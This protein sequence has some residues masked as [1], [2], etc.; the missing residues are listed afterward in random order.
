[1]KHI[2][3]CTF[4]GLFLIGSMCSNKY[5]KPNSSSK[6]QS[7]RAIQQAKPYL[8]YPGTCRQALEFYEECFD[9]EITMMQTFKE[10]SVDVPEELKQRIFNSEFRA[11]ELCFMAS[12]DMPGNEVTTGSNFALF[13]TFSERNEKEKVFQRLSEGGRILFPMEDNFGMLEDRFGIRWMME[14]SD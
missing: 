6:L 11:G 7:A 1:M 2:P 9:G 13:L 3:Y 4:L 5:E 14:S 10:A 12:D 8:M